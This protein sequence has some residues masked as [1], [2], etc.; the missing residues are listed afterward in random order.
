MQQL[1]GV[2]YTVVSQVNPHVLPFFFENRGSGG[3]PTLHREGYGWSVR[4]VAPTQHR[5]A[6][7]HSPVVSFIFWGCTGHRRGGFLGSLLEDYLKL[8]MRKWLHLLQNLNLLP[9][10]LGQDWTFVFLQKFG[11]TVTIVPYL[12]LRDYLHVISD[13]TRATM[14]DYML[15]GERVAWPKLSMIANRV[16]IEQALHRAAAAAAS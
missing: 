14:A 12:R 8:D 11:G 2:N 7:S 3:S 4:T 10:V 6:P 13:P 1:F 5:Q 15:G 9:R 16:R